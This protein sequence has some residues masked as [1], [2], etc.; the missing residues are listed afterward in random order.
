[1]KQKTLSKTRAKR[2]L[3]HHEKGSEV[4]RGARHIKCGVAGCIVALNETTRKGFP[5]PLFY[6]K[7]E[8]Q[9]SLIR[10]VTSATRVISRYIP[11]LEYYKL[12]LPILRK[13]LR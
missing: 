10:C 1:M 8:A 5:A 11:Y 9:E 2:D 6:A 7:Y 4:G 3:Q 13:L 12:K